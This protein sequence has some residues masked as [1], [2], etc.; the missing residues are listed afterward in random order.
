ML[1][2]GCLLVVICSLLRWAFP[3]QGWLKL[4]RLLDYIIAFLHWRRLAGP[5]LETWGLSRAYGT[6]GRLTFGRFSTDALSSLP[7]DQQVFREANS[8]SP[9]D[10][11]LLFG[12]SLLLFDFLFLLS[13]SLLVGA[14]SFVLTMTLRENRLLSKWLNSFSYGTII[15]LWTHHWQQRL[16]SNGAL[17]RHLSRWSWTDLQSGSTTLN[18]IIHR[19]LLLEL[20]T[21]F[22]QKL[23]LTRRL[24]NS[25]HLRRDLAHDA[26]LGK[27]ADKLLG[28]LRCKYSQILHV[29]AHLRY[30][31]THW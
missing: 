12:C 27:S 9:G 26:V 13:R 14:N 15:F 29:I 30:L 8:V 20:L 21:Q 18:R 19:Q 31:L 11:P 23:V 10:E 4:T 22:V 24:I 6:E 16:S 7:I 17:R 2:P 1:L 5:L 28:L 3:E 25:C